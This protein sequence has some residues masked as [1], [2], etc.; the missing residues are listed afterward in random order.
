MDKRKW[1]DRNCRFARNVPP[2]A[3]VAVPA[4][5]ADVV[6][7]KLRA[8]PLFSRP[9]VQRFAAELE[10]RLPVDQADIG[11]LGQYLVGLANEFMEPTLAELIARRL[12]Q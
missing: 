1:V 11:H 9:D 8:D 6:L 10:K 5:N 12:S 2:E 3:P 4:I 7:Q